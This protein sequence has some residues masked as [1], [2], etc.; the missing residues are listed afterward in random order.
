MPIITSLEP[1]LGRLVRVTTIDY[2]DILNN[3]SELF[4]DIERENFRSLKYFI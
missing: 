4:F 2:S 3:L 1:G